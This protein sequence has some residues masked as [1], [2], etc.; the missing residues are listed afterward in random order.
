MAAPA[1][2]ALVLAALAALPCRGTDADSSSRTFDDAPGQAQARLE[3]SQPTIN[4]VYE[5][6]RAIPGTHNQTLANSN[7]SSLN[8]I[9]SFNA[10]DNENEGFNVT[11]SH[12]R[13]GYDTIVS[14]KDGAQV[15][16]HRVALDKR[17]R[18]R[19]VSV[20]RAEAEAEA[21]A[22][23]AAP[24]RRRRPA[25]A[26]SSAPLLNYIFDAYSNTHHQHHRNDS[27]FRTSGGSGIYAAAAPELEALVGS[28]AHLDCKVDALHDKLVS[29]VRRKSDQEP[30][31]LLTTGTQ[32]YTADDRYSAR[33]IPPDTWRL[34]VRE[35]RP[36]DAAKYDC[37]LSAHPPR[38]ARVTL[39]V[40]EVSVRIVDGAG[41]GVR[42]Q[43]CEEGSTAALRCEVRG[44]RMDAGPA[45]ALLWHR[46]DTLLNDDTTRGGISVRTELGARGAS[47]TLLVARVR[48]ADAGRYR[49][50]VARALRPAPPPATV[51]LHVIKGESLAELHA[52]G[53][54]AAGGAAGGAL[55][56]RRCCRWPPPRACSRYFTNKMFNYTTMLL[57]QIRSFNVRPI[58]ARRGNMIGHLIR[59]LLLDHVQAAEPI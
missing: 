29:W 35:V 50:S 19:A 44:L 40:P 18:K 2:A 45:P 58:D 5:M 41:A 11:N 49:C 55:R 16:V 10:E 36:A 46:K 12:G 3:R 56:A 51:T 53:A 9:S 33:F 38:T 27:V 6:L 13:G 31:E 25:E 4:K 1:A 20:V 17:N 15:V 48:G 7:Y 57:L 37:Q 22:V 52:G 54:G 42:E 59:C 23:T 32:Q 21:G 26:G 43:V 30:M 28:T 8:L 34:Q 47:S 24:E 39:R 14:L